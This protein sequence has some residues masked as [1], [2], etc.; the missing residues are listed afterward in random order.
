MT[1]AVFDGLSQE[2]IEPLQA[3]LPVSLMMNVIIN[4]NYNDNH[5]YCQGMTAFPLY[6]RYGFVEE[7]Q[8]VK[9]TR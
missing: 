1:T 8:Q 6:Q 7:D 9:P 2:T 4:M 3:H 5:H